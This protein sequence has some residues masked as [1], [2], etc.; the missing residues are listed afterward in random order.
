MTFA[1]CDFSQIWLR[2]L[3]KIQKIQKIP[4]I[5]KNP[6]IIKNPENPENPENLCKNYWA[7]G[8]QHLIG[9]SDAEFR[10]G[11]AAAAP[12]MRR[13]RLEQTTL[14]HSIGADRARLEPTI[15][16]PPMRA[17]VLHITRHNYR[18]TAVAV[19]RTT[20]R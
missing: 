3:L 18:T 4:E 6:E 10:G 11:R 12:E 5:T 14:Q 8:V 17:K 7:S 1:E 13:A 15:P 20:L 16:V 9:F 2:K 19:T